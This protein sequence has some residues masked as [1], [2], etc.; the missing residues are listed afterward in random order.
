MTT[1]ANQLRKI[2]ESAK[3]RLLAITEQQAS[4]KPHGEKWSLKEILGHLI[5]SSGN[6]HQRIVRMQE[7]S[8]IG[9]FNYEQEHWV[10]CQRY[11]LEGWTDLVHLWYFANKHL[12]HIAEHIDPQS[13]MNVCDM[14][15][16]KPATLEFV[17]TDYL[18]H[19]QHHLDQIFSGVDPKERMKWEIVQ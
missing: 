3:P 19:L 16:P 11:R 2:I 5:D 14:G 8:A 17:V 12:A 18:R 4:E 15:Y 10:E 1:A 7:A 13:L 9:A 6:N